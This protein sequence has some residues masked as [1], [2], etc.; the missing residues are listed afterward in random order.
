MVK[1]QF[2]RDFVNYIAKTYGNDPGKMLVHTGVIGWALSSMAQVFA[3]VLND[4]IPKKQKL[5][6]IP[7]EIADA[8]VNILS[9]YVITQSCKAIALK[10]VNSGRWLPSSVKKF[11][12]EKGVKDVG[13]RSFDV[14]K[15]GNL[16]D[17]LALDFNEFRN[18]IDVIATTAGS[19][20]SCNI[21]TPVI[22]NQI[23]A[24][25]QKT[26][27]S[28]MDQDANIRNLKFE[29]LKPEYYTSPSVRAFQNASYNKTYN[30]KGSMT[31]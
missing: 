16:T 1:P 23:A 31:I 30:S 20:L 24:H 3:I 10:V 13:K 8:C 28:K 12:T 19:I 15:H 6:L 4:K 14:L 9:F 26:S 17:E 18:G 25:R 5:F 2:I 11:L 27:L 7:Q 22:R 29:E 21:V